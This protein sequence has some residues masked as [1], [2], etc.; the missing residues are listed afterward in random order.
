MPDLR[1]FGESGAL[2]ARFNIT[3]AAG[4]VLSVIQAL[5]L[6]QYMLVGHS[7]GGK[8]AMAIAAQWPAGLTH[9]VLLAP[10]PPT[11]EP[12][13]PADRA[14]LLTSQHDRAA[15]EKNICK[16]SAQSLPETVFRQAI[17]DRLRTAPDAWRW[18]LEQG[19][20]QDI[21]DT[22]TPISVPCQVLVGALDTN[23]PA[24]LI[25]AEVMPHLL[26]GK[27]RIVPGAG[28]LWPLEAP[29]EVAQAI[30]NFDF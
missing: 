24:S 3:A 10:P 27:L 17:N 5:G 12:I 6:Q 1:G 16:G 15:A 18:W 26:A 22:L 11:P 28:H 30:E 8:I 9:L 13:Q 19:S 29:Q 4:D 20:R 23:M 7:M 2:P 25:Q 21:S 14:Q